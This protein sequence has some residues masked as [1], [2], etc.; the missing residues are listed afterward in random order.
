ML[1]FYFGRPA[2]VH[3]RHRIDNVDILRWIL[4]LKERSMRK[5]MQ[6]N[7]GYFFFL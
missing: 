1:L 7:L 5:I 3:T 2:C 4:V 6:S